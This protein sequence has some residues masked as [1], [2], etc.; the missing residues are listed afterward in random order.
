MKK[1]AW[2]YSAGFLLAALVLPTHAV[3]GAN[4]TC[5][6]SG[7]DVNEGQTACIKTHKGMML[8]KCERVANNTSWKMLE[9]PCPF[10]NL[11]TPSD[12]I[13]TAAI[14]IQKK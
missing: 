11:Q 6:H 9:E 5:R 2:K 8:A 14:S 12:Q 10:S 7:G 3:A 13:M 4:C 1:F